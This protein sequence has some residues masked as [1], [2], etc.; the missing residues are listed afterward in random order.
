MT[1]I[2]KIRKVEDKWQIEDWKQ[3]WV[4]V[5]KAENIKCGSHNATTYGERYPYSYEYH[6]LKA[7]DDG[8]DNYFHAHLLPD[9]TWSLA[10]RCIGPKRRWD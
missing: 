2:V 9:K 3:R 8:G 5:D 1:H 6:W 7:I 10:G 4:Q